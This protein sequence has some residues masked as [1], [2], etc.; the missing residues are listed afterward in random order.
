VKCSPNRGTPADDRSVP[1]ARAWKFLLPW[2][3]LPL[4]LTI[5]TL[6]DRLQHGRRRTRRKEAG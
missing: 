5:I 2:A 1:V 6:I 3:V 4:A